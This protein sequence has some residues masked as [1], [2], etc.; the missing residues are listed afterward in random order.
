LKPVKRQSRGAGFHVHVAEHP[1]DEYD[2]LE[3]S[4][5]RV[6]DRLQ[7]HGILGPDTIVVHAVHIDGREMQLLSETN[8]WVTHQPRSNMNNAVGIAVRRVDA[9]Y[10]YTSLPGK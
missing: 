7:K 2:S 1:A 8:T 6:V 10:G 4:G 9:A 5:L 3:K